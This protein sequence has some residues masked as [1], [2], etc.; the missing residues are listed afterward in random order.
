[1][2]RSSGKGRNRPPRASASLRQ[3]KRGRHKR[4]ASPETVRWEEEHLIPPCPPWLARDVYVK[5][6]TLRSSL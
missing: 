6:A 1:M 3:D 4:A 5:L 2:S